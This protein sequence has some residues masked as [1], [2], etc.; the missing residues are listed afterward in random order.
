MHHVIDDSALLVSL[1]KGKL[2]CTAFNRI[3][4]FT[5][6]DRTEERVQKRCLTGA[7][8][9]CNNK[10][11]TVTKAGF[12]ERKH[13]V[14]ERVGVDKVFPI[15]SLRVKHTDRDRDTSIGI[16]NGFFQR[17]DTGVIRQVSLRDGSRIVDNHTRMVKQLLYD[18]DGVLGREEM[19]LCFL[20]TTVK[21]S[22]SHIIPTVDIDLLKV[23]VCKVLCEDRVFRHF[24][25]KAFY[26]SFGVI[27]C[28]RI[29]RII[30]ILTDIRFELGGLALV[31]EC[32]CVVLRNI[33]LCETYKRR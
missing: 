31:D 26:Q 32:C 19:L 5:I 13:I 20:N 7:C 12:K 18:V 14:G 23:G 15:Y 2:S 33:A 28:Y 24:G 11:H 1:D 21:V 6:G 10:G 30:K 17:G 22:Q 16:H 8:S 9:T 27:P 25:E 3:D 29:T 4:T